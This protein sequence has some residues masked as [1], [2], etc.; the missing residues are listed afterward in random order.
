[1]RP[2]AFQFGHLGLEIMY[3]LRLAARLRAPLWLI[4]PA[5]AVNSALYGLTADGVTIKVFDG[6]A[7]RLL[8]RA[9]FPNHVWTLHVLGLGTQ[10]GAILY[11]TPFHFLVSLRI[12]VFVRSLNNVP[13][14]PET[15]SKWMAEV[16]YRSRKRVT[17]SRQRLVKD[18][19]KLGKRTNRHWTKLKRHAQRPSRRIYRIRKFL[20]SSLT[21]AAWRLKVIAAGRGS[22]TA[23]CLLALRAV[24]VRLSTLVNP[25]VQPEAVPPS[26]KTTNPEVAPRSPGDLDEARPA[27]MAVL[28]SPVQPSTGVIVAGASEDQAIAPA[29]DAD[30]DT[31]TSIDQA[32]AEP[33]DI[34]VAHER[35]DLYRVANDVSPARAVTAYMTKVK[36]VS[37]YYKRMWLARTPRSRI[38]AHLLPSL[39]GPGRE[40]SGHSSRGADCR[41]A[42][43]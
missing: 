21:A 7:G 12:Q 37:T 28:E 30:P 13:F 25:R 43:A 26:R 32:L 5:N 29:Q 42:C 2:N 15:L 9:F 41:A 31:S 6:W 19:H 14:L 36:I 18:A 33:E 27:S 34:P 23:K 24:C 11:G 40:A 35:I 4:R 22:W 20:K 3:G 10:K 39:G 8:T 38:P 16:L 1:M 17:K